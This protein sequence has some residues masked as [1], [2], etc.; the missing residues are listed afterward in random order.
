M[1]WGLSSPA[2]DQELSH[3][4]QD[5]LAQVR[6]GGLVDVP[7]AVLACHQAWSSLAQDLEP[8]AL[9]AAHERFSLWV[10]IAARAAQLD[11]DALD[12]S[13]RLGLI[14]ASPYST[15]EVIDHLAPALASEVGSAAELLAAVAAAIRQGMLSPQLR[16]SFTGI[17]A[18]TQVRWKALPEIGVPDRPWVQFTPG[19]SL[20]QSLAH[21]G[22]V[23][24]PG[25]EDEIIRRLADFGYPPGRALPGCAALV[26]TVATLL[27]S[28]RR[29][30]ALQGLGTLARLDHRESRSQHPRS[31]ALVSLPATVSVGFLPDPA[32]R[33]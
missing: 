3:L 23:V 30:L 4:A 18:W 17:G 20:K 22:A 1:A 25:P 14:Q 9:E 33:A 8:D 26:H 29:A 16:A 13:I 28:P 5:C 27:A 32:L 11:G 2:K 7:A 31:G 6:A 10:R 12:E 21:Q 15:M 24:P 19:R